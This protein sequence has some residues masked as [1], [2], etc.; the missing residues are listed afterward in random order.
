[1]RI[2]K[3]SIHSRGPARPIVG[4]LVVLALGLSACGDTADGNQGD[5]DSEGASA[6]EDSSEEATEYEEREITFGAY[7]P[8]E[9]VLWDEGL[10]QMATDLEEAS[11][12]AWTVETYPAE[13]LGA[14]GDSVSI[15]Q[16]GV[17]DI[18]FYAGTYHASELPLLQGWAVP[19]AYTPQ[20]MASARWE[21][22]HDAESPFVEELNEQNLVP[23]GVIQTPGYEFATTDVPLD[24]PDALDG[25]DLRSG[26]DGMTSVANAFGAQGVEVP[27]TEIFESLDRGMVDGVMYSFGS[28]K[29]VNIQDLLNHATVGLEWG[30]VPLGLFMSG[31]VWGDLNDAEKELVYDQGREASI[32]STNL[33]LEDNT[34]DLEEFVENGLET[35][36]WSD[37]D[38]E[39]FRA[40]FE[41]VADDWAANASAEGHDGEA[42]YGEITERAD[43]KAADEMEF[44]DS[45]EDWAF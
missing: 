45:F 28:W 17:A 32:R 2:S 31:D 9:H 36:E 41:D 7:I 26:G 21:A 39:R 40:T 20:Q 37:D 3:S 15:L 42:I 38:K 24:S 30:T 10:D 16:S 19:A 23:I 13:Q 14:A 34:S 12:G 27:S 29:S 25:L 43:P 4:T 44:M 11:G 5:E 22:F 1:M 18:A 35:T 8:T 33:F 6:A